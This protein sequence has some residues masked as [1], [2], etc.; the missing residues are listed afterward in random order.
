[1][2][3]DK[4]LSRMLMRCIIASYLLKF[5]FLWCVVI[6]HDEAKHAKYEQAPPIFLAHHLFHGGGINFMFME[7]RCV[8]EVLNLNF[9]I[10]VGLEILGLK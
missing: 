6:L 5:I 1:M 7:Y 9:D 8:G 3:N 2:E 4:S 10:G